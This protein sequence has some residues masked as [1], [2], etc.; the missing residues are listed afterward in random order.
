MSYQAYQNAHSSAESPKQTEYRLFAQVTRA[1]V[2][3]QETENNLDPRVIKALDWNRSIWS[4]F[5]TDC[6]TDGNQLP[7]ETR[8]AIIS[9]DIWVS[10]HTTKIMRGEAEIDDL[11]DI[12]RTIMEGLSASNDAPK[13][14]ESNVEG[15]PETGKTI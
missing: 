6:G 15:I 5:S 12:N 11:I 14:Q 10:K 13:S 7:D 3:A 2:E 8:A 1:L 4:H 9:L